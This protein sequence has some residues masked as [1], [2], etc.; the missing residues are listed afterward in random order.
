MI[1]GDATIEFL[2]RSP[3]LGSGNNLGSAGPT[4]HGTPDGASDPLTMLSSDVVVT[5]QSP[6]AMDFLE[7]DRMR[8]KAAK[9]P[10]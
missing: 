1:L 2:L 3:R 6:G 10:T 8:V 5:S 4:Q 7:V 9:L